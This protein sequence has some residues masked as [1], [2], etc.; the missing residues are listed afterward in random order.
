M[1]DA[2]TGNFINRN[3]LEGVYVVNTA[4]QTQN[5]FDSST[6]PLDQ[7]GSVFNDPIIEMQFANNQVIGNGFSTT[8]QAGGAPTSTGLVV[9]VGT[10]GATSSVIDPGGFASIGSIVAIGGTP[11]GE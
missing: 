3:L 7:N 11:F 4:S 2:V 8:S 5:Q 10:S 6:L 9:R 1:M